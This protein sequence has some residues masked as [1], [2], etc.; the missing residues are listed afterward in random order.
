P[1]LAIIG[2]T[3][4]S[5]KIQIID[6]LLDYTNE[7]IIVGSICYTFLKV[8]YNM[9]IGSSLFDENSAK[10]VNSLMEKA[11][12]NNVNLILQID[13]ICGDKFDKNCNNKLNNSIEGIPHDWMGLDI[14]NESIKI[15]EKVINRAKTIFWNG[16]P[17]VFEWPKTSKGTI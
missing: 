3:N 4:V 15:F 8:I 9:N 16:P 13:L 14:G 10:I 5:D 7:M 2:G 6:S 12:R 1:Y 17:G 11:I